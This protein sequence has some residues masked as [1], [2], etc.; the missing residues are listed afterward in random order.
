MSTPDE[1]QPVVP[2]A[3]SPASGASAKPA[4]KKENMLLNLICNIALPTLILMK[5]SSDKWLGPLWGLLVA[6]AF[7]V[8]YGAWDMATRKHANMISIVGFCGVLLGGGL[9][10]L[11]VSGFW[12]AVKEAL[13]PS[14]IGIAV[15]VSARLK[16]PLV[17]ALIY[18]DQI[19]DTARVKAALEERGTHGAFEKL[20][21]GANKWLALTFFVSAVLNFFLARRLITATPRTEEFNSQL[22]QMQLWSWPVIVLPSMVMLMVILW[23]LLGGL[24]RLTGLEQD[25][26]F[27]GGEKDG[28]GK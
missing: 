20:L 4:P 5:F 9:G 27:R 18:N 23:K 25:A 16:K 7:P 13:V 10:L 6:L 22:G 26:I 12:F 8:C 28:Q 14:I 15:L 24:Q 17:R 19:I 21:A 1:S 2:A 3:A 11:K